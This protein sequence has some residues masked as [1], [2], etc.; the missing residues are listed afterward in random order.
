MK[1]Y[2]L[3]DCVSGGENLKEGKEY[4]FTTRIANKLI[5]R[6]YASD[7]MPVKKAKEES[8]D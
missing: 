2:M 6:G 4:D 7:K 8:E 3:K 5:A 1:V